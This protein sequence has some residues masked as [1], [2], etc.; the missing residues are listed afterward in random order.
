MSKMVTVKMS[1]WPGWNMPRVDFMP[2][3]PLTNLF[4]SIFIVTLNLLY[5]FP[6]EVK[7]IYTKYSQIK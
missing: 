7:C 5:I 2:E 1:E 6:F 4:S 3:Q